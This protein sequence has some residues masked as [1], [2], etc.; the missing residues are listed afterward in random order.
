MSIG[1]RFL[2]IYSFFDEYKT[3]KNKSTNEWYD[4]RKIRQDGSYLFSKYSALAYFSNRQQ[5]F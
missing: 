5:I 2:S 4:C 1:S 3:T